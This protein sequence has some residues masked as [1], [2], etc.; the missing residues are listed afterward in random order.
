MHRE[1][2]NNLS[3][4]FFLSICGENF[5]PPSD[6]NRFSPSFSPSFFFHHLQAHFIYCVIYCVIYRLI[7][8]LRFV[9]FWIYRLIYRLKFVITP[10]YRLIYRDITN[11]LFV[12]LFNDFPVTALVGTY[13][14]NDALNLKLAKMFLHIP[15]CDAYFF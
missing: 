15:R 14:T 2:S 1:D 13:A 5:A 11:A 9:L 12:A 8:R 3:C 7:Y 4:N 6:K 10:I